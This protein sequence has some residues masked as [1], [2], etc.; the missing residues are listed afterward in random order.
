MR[1]ET[2][3]IGDLESEAL[4]L[5]AGLSATGVSRDG[6]RHAARLRFAL[7]RVEELREQARSA[8]GVFVPARLAVAESI[9]AGHVARARS[10]ARRVPHA[11]RAA[12]GDLPQ[13]FERRSAA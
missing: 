10:F 7:A 4:A 1:D 9:L 6:A 11:T 13:A 3:S 12:E 2:P 5:A 8:G